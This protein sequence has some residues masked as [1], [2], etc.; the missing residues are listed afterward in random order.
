MSGWPLQGPE[1]GARADLVHD[2]VFAVLREARDAPGEPFA[3]ELG[4]ALVLH[5]WARAVGVRCRYGSAPLVLHAWARVFDGGL[6]PFAVVAHGRAGTGYEG[7]RVDTFAV[8]TVRASHLDAALVALR[9]TSRSVVAALVAVPVRAGVGEHG[10]RAEAIEKELATLRGLRATVPPG[11]FGD[12]GLAHRIRRLEAEHAALGPV[13]TALH[14]RLDDGG[15]R[16]SHLLMVDA[17]TTGAGCT[18]PVVRRD[19]RLCPADGAEPQPLPE[20][21]T[22]ALGG[23]PWARADARRP[24]EASARVARRR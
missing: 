7:V 16:S 4:M 17:R 12:G 14:A 15:E 9:R 11:P 5:A 10:D 19:G 6:S 13:A 22:A 2:A 24:P 18:V 3:G 20:S 21:F 1:D 8:D 23:F